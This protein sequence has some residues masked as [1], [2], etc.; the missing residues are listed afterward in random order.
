MWHAFLL[1]TVKIQYR[2]WIICL[3]GFLHKYQ[4]ELGVCTNTSLKFLLERHGGLQ[5]KGAWNSDVEF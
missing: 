2:H 5:T 3:F 4:N 1:M